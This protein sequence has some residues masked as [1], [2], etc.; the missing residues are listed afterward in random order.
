[1]KFQKKASNGMDKLIQRAVVKAGREVLK[2]FGKDRVKYMKS[3]H[4]WDCVTDADLMSERII[5]SEISKKHI[6]HGIIAE[7]SGKKNSDSDY[8]WIIDPIDGTM[9]FSTDVP[10][11]GVMAALAHHGRVVLSAIY[12]PVTK[13]LFF[14]K[15]GKGAYLNGKRIH[16]SQRRDLNRTMGV[17]Q[18]TLR[19]QPKKLIDNILKNVKSKYFALSS[20]GAMSVNACYVA[21]GRR[22]WAVPMEGEVHDFAP[23]YLL[24]KESGCKV[25]DL[26]G[27]PWKLSKEAMVAANPVLHKQLLK[28]TKNI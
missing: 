14:A 27:N 3:D 19:G 15:E 22:D 12:L 21:S 25:T 26:K 8:I 1:M 7:E 28:L 9:N 17:G 2:R 20:F 11:F 4:L 18:L 6:D 23:A 10:L 24:L 16:C 13:E 5:I